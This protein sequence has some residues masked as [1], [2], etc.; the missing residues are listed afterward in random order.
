MVSDDSGPTDRV[1]AIIQDADGP[2]EQVDQWRLVIDDRERI[3]WRRAWLAGSSNVRDVETTRRYQ[4]I[5]ITVNDLTGEWE[6]ERTDNTPGPNGVTFT[7]DSTTEIG[8][9]TTR[10]GAIKLAVEAMVTSRDI[11]GNVAE[12]TAKEWVQ[13]R[14]PEPDFTGKALTD[15]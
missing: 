15:F 1:V 10:Q 2:P 8:A 13:Q 3:E 6:V 12:T 7:A 4:A 14:R 9:A 5:E 11:A